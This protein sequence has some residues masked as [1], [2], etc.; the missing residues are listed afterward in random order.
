MAKPIPH[1]ASR[2]SQ[3]GAAC[4]LQGAE[5][6][7]HWEKGSLKVF[8]LTWS[9]IH[10]RGVY[11]LSGQKNKKYWNNI[12]VEVPKH[13][14]QKRLQP[15][16]TTTYLNIL[17]KEVKLASFSHYF[18]LIFFPAFW[19]CHILKS[20]ALKLGFYKIPWLGLSSRHS[21]NCFV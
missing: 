5:L 11:L 13:S 18:S 20:T 10:T 17:K 15:K 19:N 2:G 14:T 16:L 21:L 6:F 1:V 3:H 8:M 4:C 9:L 7:C 12:T